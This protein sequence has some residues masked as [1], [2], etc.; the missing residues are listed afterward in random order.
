LTL[1]TLTLVKLVLAL[2]GF[3]LVTYYGERDKRIV[4][5]LLTFPLLNGVALLSSPDPI[6]VASAIYPLV[7]FNSL[8][9]WTILSAVRWLPPQWIELRSSVLLITRVLLW[10][11]AWAVGACSLMEIQEDLPTG[12]I[13]FVAYSGIAMAVIHVLWERPNRRENPSGDR[14]PRFWFDWGT[15]VALFVIV[16][17]GLAYT[18]QN[19]S[20]QRWVGMAGAFPLPGI[21]A[22][23]SLSVTTKSE[24]LISIR[25]TVLLGPVLVIPF[26]WVFGHFVNQLPPGLAGASIGIAALLVAWFIS[27]GLVIWIVPL[28][29]RWLDPLPR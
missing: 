23:A 14:A 1:Y 13:W 16:F 5:V 12:P 7:I 26:T 9:F 3:L 28:I 17:L 6:K 2:T 11:A 18:V 15:R 20:D 19:A 22:I 4:G 25:D 24:Q 21:F 10:G 27:F 29:E 8:L